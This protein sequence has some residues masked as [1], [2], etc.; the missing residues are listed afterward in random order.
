VE[1]DFE[2]FLATARLLYEGPWVAERYCAVGDFLEQHP[3]SVYPVTRQIIKRRQAARSRRCL[4]GA[5]SIDGAAA[6]GRGSLVHGRRVD[7]T[8][9]GTIY[10]I[11]AVNAD[12][13]RL[14][15]NLGYYT[16]FR[17]SPQPGPRSQCGRFSQ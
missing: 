11:D 4:S 12:P 16:N 3:Q 9:A 2:P 1:I 10:H 15:S 13:I 7:H 6:C 5:I 8:T 14:N 17:Q